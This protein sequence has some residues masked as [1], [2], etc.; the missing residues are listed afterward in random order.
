ME[1]ATL[2]RQK[3]ALPD[4]HEVLCRFNF[5]NIEEVDIKKK[6][7]TTNFYFEA[8]WKITREQKEQ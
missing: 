4:T 5:F 2:S 8:C 6:A 1:A 3:T 7:I